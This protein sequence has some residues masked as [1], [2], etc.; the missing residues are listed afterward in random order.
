MAELHALSS[1]EYALKE[2]VVDKNIRGL[3]NLIKY[4][5]ENDWIRNEEFSLYNKR[6][7]LMKIQKETF[8]ELNRIREIEQE[9]VTEQYDYI[10]IIKESLPEIRNSIAHGTSMIHSGGYGTLQICAEFIN[11]LYVE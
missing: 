8:D 1:L 9:F 5:I 7:K 6:Q 11:Q 3:R 4:A 2:K 10:D